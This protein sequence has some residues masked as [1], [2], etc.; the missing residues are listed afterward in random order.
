MYSPFGRWDISEAVPTIGPHR[1]GFLG[2][3]FRASGGVKNGK[4]QNTGKKER[5]QHDVVMVH[6]AVYGY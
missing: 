5:K 2:G 6:Y 3:I 4:T 1:G